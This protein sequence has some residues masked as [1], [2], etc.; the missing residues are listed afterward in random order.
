MGRG[1][2]SH[3]E[4]RERQ[5]AGAREEASPNEALFHSLLLED[6]CSQSVKRFKLPLIF[7]YPGSPVF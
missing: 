3:L 2:R 5:A 4:L 7:L 6:S 1:G